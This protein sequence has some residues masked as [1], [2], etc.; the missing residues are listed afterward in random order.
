MFFS[1]KS[2]CSCWTRHYNHYNHK[3]THVSSCPRF[4]ISSLHFCLLLRFLA[5]WQPGSLAGWPVDGPAWWPPPSPVT[6][7]AHLEPRSRAAAG[8]AGGWGRP[9]GR[10]ARWSSPERLGSLDFKG[11]FTGNPHIS[12]QKN[13]VSGEDFPSNQSNDVMCWGTF[14]ALMARFYDKNWVFLGSYDARIQKHMVSCGTCITNNA[15][16][17][18]KRAPGRCCCFV[19]LKATTKRRSEHWN[20]AL[21]SNPNGSDGLFCIQQKLSRPTTPG[22]SSNCFAASC[23]TCVSLGDMRPKRL[24]LLSWRV[25][26]V[27]SVAVHVGSTCTWTSHS[28]AWFMLRKRTW[29]YH[30]PPHP[31]PPTCNV[32]TC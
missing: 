15:R 3:L 16:S 29:R 21:A 25:R 8:A 28:V 27:V 9:S 13:M 22:F 23:C 12:W 18:R 30:A 19:F 5:A 7:L 31:T 26:S 1:A 32:Q 2:W 10:R 4:I 6:R 17:G 11:R 14:H 20:S 24:F